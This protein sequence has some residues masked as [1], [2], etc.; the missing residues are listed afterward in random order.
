M[1]GVKFD[2]LST[3]AGDDPEDSILDEA[4]IKLIKGLTKSA[5]HRRQKDRNV[6]KLT[7]PV[8]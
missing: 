6:L 4:S 1:T 3:G 7:F 8:A 5:A 2:P